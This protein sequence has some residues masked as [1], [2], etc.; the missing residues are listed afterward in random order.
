MAVSDRTGQYNEWAL[1]SQ[2][3]LNAGYNKYGFANADVYYILE[4]AEFAS[5]LSD[6]TV[7]EL[8]AGDEYQVEPPQPSSSQARGKMKASSKYLRIDARDHDK[9]YE[10]YSPF[11]SGIIRDFDVDKRHQIMDS[12]FVDMLVAHHPHVLQGVELYNDKLIVHSL[13]N[14]MFDSHFPETFSSVI[15]YST[16]NSQTPGPS[17]MGFNFKPIYI[18][19]YIPKPAIG[20]LGAHT[21][22][23]LADL[24]RDLNTFIG[25]TIYKTLFTINVDGSNISSSSNSTYSYGDDRYITEVGIEDNNGN[26]VI[27]GKLSRPVRLAN[28][29]TATIE[30]TID[31]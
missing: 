18:D 1:G 27:V 8:H 22:N 10:N 19:H 24:S 6:F 13:G 29:T 11:N 20:E 15:F 3:Y 30:L 7:V 21:L 25:A 23:H 12:P 16:V 4:Q 17:A 2:P 14:F 26:L 9:E 31:F 5:S 28:S